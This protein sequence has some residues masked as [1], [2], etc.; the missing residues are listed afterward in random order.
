[1]S[2]FNFLKRNNNIQLPKGKC[3]VSHS[4]QDAKYIADLS[5]YI[6]ADTN[7]FKFP[8]IDVSRKEM[9]SNAFLKEIRFSTSLVYLD[10]PNSSNSPW[11]ILERDYALRSGIK[12]FRFHPLSGKLYRDTSKPLH[13]P[14]FPSYTRED[15]EQM[16]ELLSILKNERYFDLFT[17]SDI[18]NG[19]SWANEIEMALLGRL[20]AG[21]YLIYFAS[22]DSMNSEFII[23]EIKMAAENYEDRILLVRLDSTPLP[24]EFQHINSIDLFIDND[25][26]IDFNKLDTLIVQV[27]F[28]INQNQGS[29]NKSNQE[30]V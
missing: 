29:K 25:T 3:F 5:P 6:Q 11:V 14:V 20:K 28:L 2:L 30:Q 24:A 23:N 7:L 13:L 18:Q 4:Y 21:G 19:A 1:M 27:Y 12:V 22:K 9:V 8:R 10:S 17:D 15:Q 26:D 16:E